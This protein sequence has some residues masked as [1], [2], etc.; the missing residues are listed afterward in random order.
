MT[1]K[2]N[3]DRASQFAQQA[4]QFAQQASQFQNGA[5]RSFPGRLKTIIGSSS[6]RSF[7]RKAGVSDTFVRQCLAGKSEPTRPVLMAMAAAGGVL[8]GWLATGDDPAIL[9]GA[10]TDP[11]STEKIQVDDIKGTYSVFIKDDARSLPSTAQLDVDALREA[12]LM[13]LEAGGGSPAGRGH[14]RSAALIAICYQALLA[15]MSPELMH[16]LLAVSMRQ[17]D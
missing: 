12:V 5:A 14:E 3:C 9:C 17:P 8:V 7:A 11:D 6:V 10:P 4:S 13:V 2:T 16:D 15:G 1:A